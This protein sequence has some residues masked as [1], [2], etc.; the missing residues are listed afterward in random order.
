MPLVV[1]FYGGNWDSGARGLYRFVAAT[2]ARQGWAVAVP[3]YRLYPEI[4][5][6]AFLEDCAAAVAFLARE[7]AA[8]GLPP[9]P[10]VLAGHSAG[11][12]NAV[13]L[14][15]DRRWLSRAGAPP[16]AGAVGL[17]GPYDFLPLESGMLRDLFRADA[18]PGGLPAT[19]PIA[20]ARADAPPLLLLTGTDD[21]TV[22]P[23]NSERLAARQRALGA[24]ARLVEYP[25]LG[26]VGLIAT[27]ARG[28]PLYTGAVPAEVGRFVGALP[29]TA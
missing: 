14:A 2:L 16:P 15:L 12:Y 26:H 19:Q 17:A 25:G 7:R 27:F 4:R 24:E 9:G 20:Y 5:F 1:F 18:D 8:L 29:G 28:L 3:D 6:P 11:A 23:A 13:M 10:V 22:R 21:T